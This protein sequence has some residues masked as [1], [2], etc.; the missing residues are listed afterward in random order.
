M[1]TNL[2]F[3]NFKELKK[4]KFYWHSILGGILIIV[5]WVGLDT[6]YP[7]RSTS[8]FN[9]ALFPAAMMI[10]LT[11]F[12]IISAV[13]VAS[14][15]EEIFIRSFLIRFFIEPYNWQKVKIG[16]YTLFSFLVT[17]IFFGFAHDRW[18]VGIITGII[19]NLLLYWKKDIWL[20]IESHSIANIVLAI[21]VLYTQSWGFW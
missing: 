12:R 10:T 4:F 7:F 9:P 11:I 16:T 8:E 17:M 20:C 14:F 21:Y 6:L 13:V 1:I 18:L 2:F 5:I 15:V 3:K 19:L